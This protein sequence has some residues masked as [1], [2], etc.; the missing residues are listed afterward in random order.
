MMRVLIV[1]LLCACSVLGNLVEEKEK[2]RGAN[3][4]L[5]K[6][7]EQ[8]SVEKEVGVWKH[9]FQYGSDNHFLF[10]NRW[11]KWIGTAPWC[12]GANYKCPEYK[13]MD[14]DTNLDGEVRTH[15]LQGTFGA[16]CWWGGK[17]LCCKEQRQSD[18]V[19][20]PNP[21]FTV[22][23]KRCRR[24]RGT[25]KPDCL[26]NN[27]MYDNFNDAFNQC[28]TLPQ[29]AFITRGANGKFWLRRSDDD[30]DSSTDKMMP[31][32]CRSS[33]TSDATKW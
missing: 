10:E 15:N 29:C 23:A 16:D 14:A 20:P 19:A 13:R 4:A 12:W 30:N 24:L 28:R 5:M 9:G 32:P 27:R 11:C 21:S 1:A 31:M 17:T 2:L 8:L 18:C 26:N 6:A 3:E 25:N 7:L 22:Q 33:E